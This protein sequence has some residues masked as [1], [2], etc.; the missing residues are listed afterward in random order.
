MSVFRKRRPPVGSGDS[1]PPRRL[2]TPSS[3]S[4]SL[5]D[6]TRPAASGRSW[7]RGPRRSAGSSGRVGDRRSISPA[8][9][10][11]IESGQRLDA[12]GLADGVEQLEQEQG[13]AAG[14][15]GDLLDLVAG[16]G[17][18]LGRGVDDLDQRV[19]CR[20]ARAPWDR[21]RACPVRPSANGSPTPWR[22]TIRTWRRSRGRSRQCAAAGRA[23]PRPGGGRPR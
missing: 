5:A 8:I 21:S 13:I 23:T 15:P 22:V 6:R 16:E 4:T 14:P 9:I 18:V 3:R 10:D 12:A 1:S 7:R 11:S 17:I 19:R 2:Q 20:A